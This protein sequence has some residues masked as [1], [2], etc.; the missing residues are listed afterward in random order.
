MKAY[1]V[2]H[3]GLFILLLSGVLGACSPLEVPNIEPP[4]PKL[5]TELFPKGEFAFGGMYSG[6]E[7]LGHAN[8]A[9]GD[10]S[11]P[12]GYETQQVLGSEGEDTP[13][14]VCQKASLGAAE[15]P[16]FDFGGLYGFYIDAA[17]GSEKIYANAITEEA[18]CP[19]S[20]TAHQVYG[21]EGLDLAL[22][23][24]TRDASFFSAPKLLF[25]G[26]YG[27]SRDDEATYAH[28]VTGEASCPSGS[29]D[30]RVL[31]SDDVDW[32]L[33][34][35]M[36]AASDS[37]TLLAVTDYADLTFSPEFDRGFVAFGGMYSR[38]IDPPS[39]ST[40]EG[41]INPL[42]G[43]YSCPEGYSEHLF[44]GHAG[45]VNV[46][47]NDFNTYLCYRDFE[48]RFD[49]GLADFGGVWG[50]GGDFGIYSNPLSPD[51]MPANCR[52]A[53]LN[54]AFANGRNGCPAGFEVHQIAAE[55]NAEWSMFFCHREQKKSEATPYSVGGMFSEKRRDNPN[56][57]N[58]PNF[59]NLGWACPEAHTETRFHG[60]SN[61]AVQVDADAYFCWA[62]I[63][64]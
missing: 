59:M 27:R 23:I 63:L 3:Q 41:Y 58:I 15:L 17:D 53:T 14:F 64:N 28:A 24:C 5:P 39:G 20:Y 62:E 55:E 47:Y 35:C 46:A 48:G 52:Q 11:C 21:A 60:A 34:A 40:P 51:N 25:D 50:C 57:P 49:L 9:T 37:Q 32:P 18:S 16:A 12:S 29:L 44:R 7:T 36:R 10:W 8:P 26:L 6:D 43:G 13:L 1:R 22:Y 31:G 42:T 19:D 30:Y 4:K 33:H 54:S 2:D 45:V 38:R 61:G 56:L